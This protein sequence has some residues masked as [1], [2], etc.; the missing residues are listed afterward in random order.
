MPAIL[1]A[2]D[3]WV[4]KTTK[5]IDTVTGGKKKHVSRPPNCAIFLH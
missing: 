4:A 2:L 3:W 5:F 1:C